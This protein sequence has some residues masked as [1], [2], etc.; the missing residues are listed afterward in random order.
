MRGALLV[1]GT[2]SDAGKSTVVGGLCRLLARRGV[3][4]APFKA[5]N[6]A[7]NSWVTLD[8]GEIGRSTAAQALAAGIEPTVEMNPIL[9]KPSGDRRSQLIV[10]GRPDAQLE[11]AGYYDRVEALRPV[12]HDALA[13]LRRR[14]DVVLCE[15][16]GSPAEINLLERDL[17]NLSLARDADMAAVIVGD[18]ERG[19]VFAS[20]FGT[21]E[22]LPPDLRAVVGG[23]VINRFRGDPALLEPGPTML[24]E[25]CG[26][27][28]VGVLPHLGALPIDGEDTLVLDRW[29][30]GGGSPSAGRALDVAL[31]ALPRISNFTDLDALAAEPA[32]SVRL[33]HRAE[34]LGRPDLVVL[35][36]TKSTVADLDWLRAVGL[37]DAVR[38]AEAAGSTVLGICGGYQMLGRTIDDPVESGRGIVDGLGVL[39]V[40]TVFAPDKLV[41]RCRGRALG[42]A[43]DGYRI[44]HGRVVGG[45]PW[46]ELDGSGPEGSASG[47][48]W[49]TTVHGCLDGDDVR[50]AFL[51]RVAERS[52]RTWALSGV[53]FAE[54]RSRQYDRVADAIEEHVDLGRLERL[55]EVGAVSP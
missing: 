40:E 45:T 22:L 1:C 11:A 21:V 6:M 16:A 36:G 5:Q 10:S 55:I 53:R 20:L 3:A 31:V 38:A 39:D 54:V 23:F 34:Q 42:A 28:T 27:P 33:V 19:G 2:T 48:W 14:H 43:L 51:A 32:V 15:G 24:E 9:L 8:G 4:V 13:A 30:G 26:V 7:N 52:G 49:G 37:D 18:I 44:H 35:P 29:G 17:V 50:A 12:V 47:G 25:R 41:E 46:V